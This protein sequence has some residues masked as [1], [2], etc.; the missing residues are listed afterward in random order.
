VTRK[1]A[2]RSANAGRAPGSEG[3]GNLTG[4]TATTVIPGRS[5]KTYATGT[6]ALARS[7]DTAEAGEACARQ[8]IVIGDDDGHWRAAK[9]RL[10]AGGSGG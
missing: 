6:I 10:V 7:G 9:E 2:A 5:G 3:T 4:L 1:W 8:A